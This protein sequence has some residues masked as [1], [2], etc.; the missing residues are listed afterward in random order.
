MGHAVLFVCT[1]NVCR[2]PLMAF[3]FDQAVQASSHGDEWVVTSGGID[4][5]R[6]A[7]ICER[8]AELIA[9]EPQ[10]KEFAASHVSTAVEGD[11]LDEHELIITASRAERAALA[12]IQPSLRARTFTLREA[13]GLGKT[14][15]TPAEIQRASRRS[16]PEQVLGL[17][18]AVLNGRRGTVSFP[19]PPALRL[20]WRPVIDPQDI[21]DV[22]HAELKQ[23]VGTLK[24]LR[25]A[26][27]A[28]HGQIDDFLALNRVAEPDDGLSG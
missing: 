6:P 24:E 22:H 15:V 1:A 17:Y 5:N 2:S 27:G 3:E 11:N 8:S 19:P 23:H 18:A 14:R 7:Q 21:P 10:G 25:A 4:V 16:E 20:P 12:R 13:V 9:S 26:V 28:L